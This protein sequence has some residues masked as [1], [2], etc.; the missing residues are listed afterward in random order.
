MLGNDDQRAKVQN[1]SEPEVETIK[2]YKK[3]AATRELT[4][5]LLINEDKLS[6]GQ[7][8]RKILEAPM[9]QDFQELFFFDESGK[10]IHK[11]LGVWLDLKGMGESSTAPQ[12]R[13]CSFDA[14]DQRKILALP[15]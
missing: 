15:S 4:Y 5:I 14:V 2:N 12:L 13:C 6:A 7:L 9:L 8:Q 3:K 1:C 10:R 11:L